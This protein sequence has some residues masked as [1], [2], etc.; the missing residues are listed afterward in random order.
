V[1][2]ADILLS[3]VPSVLNRE[4]GWKERLRNDLFFLVVCKTLTQGRVQKL[5]LI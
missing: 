5:H 3:L 1:L 4:V 2:F